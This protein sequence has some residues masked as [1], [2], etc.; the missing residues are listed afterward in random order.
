MDINIAQTVDLRNEIII[1]NG[2]ICAVDIHRK[3]MTL[4]F[5]L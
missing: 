3:A 4:V 2:M 1:Y 5:T